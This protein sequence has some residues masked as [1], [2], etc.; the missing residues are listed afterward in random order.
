MKY[1]FTK[2]DLL[3]TSFTTTFAGILDDCPE[4]QGPIG[5]EHYKLLSYLSTLF[6]DSV[7]LDIGTHRGSS[8]LALSYNPTNT[9]HT[10]DI[11]EKVTNAAIKARPN[12]V[13]HMDDLFD[14]A[15]QVKWEAIVHQAP[16][17]F[18]DVDPHNGH[19]ERAFYEWLKRINY[20]G[21]VVCDDIWFFKEMRDNFWS[22]LLDEERYDLT[23]FGHWSGTGV[24][25]FNRDITFP[26]ADNS[27]WTLV[28]A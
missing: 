3:S 14:A 8:A 2:E 21:F 23:D 19:M 5:K 4:F 16:F 11:C 28:T 9:I 26:K 15:T 1:S 18:L 13:F 25:T 27:D 7:I 10:F 22:T 24:F 17:I 20:K 12:I 6:N